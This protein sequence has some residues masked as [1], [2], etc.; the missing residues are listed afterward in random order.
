M[1][2][3]KSHAHPLVKSVELLD[4]LS[5][6]HACLG[7]SFN[8]DVAQEYGMRLSHIPS[9]RVSDQAVSIFVAGKT[10]HLALKGTLPLAVAG[11]VVKSS[12]DASQ[13]HTDGYR[14]CQRDEYDKR[15]EQKVVICEAMTS[16]KLSSTVITDSTP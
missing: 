8:L 1:N 15:D 13:L 3:D 4:Q 6:G 14:C 12:Y 2:K 11:R 9:L 5:L 7:C 16:I 10:E